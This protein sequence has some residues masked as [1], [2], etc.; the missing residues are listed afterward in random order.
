MFRIN[1]YILIIIGIGLIL[2]SIWDY[3]VLNKF[4]CVTR[5]QKGMFK[6]ISPIFF[7]INKI[8][9]YWDGLVGIILLLIG[10]YSVIT[11]KD[12]SDIIHD[13]FYKY[14]DVIINNELENLHELRRITESA[15]SQKE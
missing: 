1:S 11:D 5:D 12:L 10:L 2:S 15:K 14:N 4:T 13:I 3:K 6:K 7:K 8:R 9:N